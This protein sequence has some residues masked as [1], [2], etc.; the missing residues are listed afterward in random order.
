MTDALAAERPMA[1]TTADGVGRLTDGAA[2]YRAMLKQFTTTDY[3]PDQVHRM[4]LDE[5]ARITAEMDPLLE[6]QGL[7]DGTVAER[8]NAL[9]KDPK[10]QFGNDAA[11]RRQALAQ[12]QRILDEVAARMPESFRTIPAG[13]LQVVRVPVASEKGSSGA[14]YEPAAMD[15]S[16]PGRFFANLR[17]MREVP[18][19]GMKT[20]SYHEGIPGHHFQIDMAHGLKDMP[21]IRQQPIYTA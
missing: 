21:F 6:G 2:F 9:G 8:M 7:A 3:T 17:D 4:G 12:Y 15:G 5:V 20:L 18:Q 19:W 13:K 11:G 10:Y 1:E 14:Y 16:R